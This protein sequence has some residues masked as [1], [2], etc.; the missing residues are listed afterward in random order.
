MS[1]PRSTEAAAALRAA[2]GGRWA[3]PGPRELWR[4]RV[5]VSLAVRIFLLLVGGMVAATFLARWIVESLYTGELEKLGRTAAIE[6]IGG[7][8]RMLDALPPESRPAGARGLAFERLE[9]FWPR[10]LGT[11]TLLETSVADQLARELERSPGPVRLEALDPKPC[12]VREHADCDSWAKR[13]ALEVALADGQPV[14][15]EYTTRWFTVDNGEWIIPWVVG[16][17]MLVVGAWVSVRIATRPLRELAAHAAGLGRDLNCAPMSENGPTE[18][19]HA[20]A[21]MNAMQ[22]QLRRQIDERTQMLA[23]IA[24]DLKTPLTRMR[25]RLELLADDEVRRKLE[26]DVAAMRGLVDEGL[27]LARSLETTEAT[28]RIDISALLDTLCEDA[29]DT[30]ATARFEGEAGLVI[31]TRPHALRRVLDNLIDNALKHGGSAA[32]AVCRDGSELVVS[33]R[34]RGPG[35][36][37][38]HLDDVL[39]PYFRLEASRSRETGGSGLGLAIATNLVSVLRGRLTLRNRPEGGLEAE[40]RLPG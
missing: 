22:A 37:A 3:I 27:E 35:I 13:F 21:A 20:A 9:V 19:R 2:P 39:K 1:S 4:R 25:L 14:R 24:H 8:V 38:E 18:V 34:D 16:I 15:V 30:G 12:S 29:R 23:A 26:E 6:R 5:R 31:R 36:P 33:V 17:A 40:I 11:P 10:Q 32:V 7:A 28:Q